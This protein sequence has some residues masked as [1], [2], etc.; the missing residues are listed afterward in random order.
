MTMVLYYSNY[1]LVLYYGNY[2]MVLDYGNYTIVTIVL[3]FY[4]RTHI[5]TEF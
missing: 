5:Y 2:T 1:T 4:N 3:E